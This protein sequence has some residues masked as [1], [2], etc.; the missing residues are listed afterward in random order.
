LAKINSGG[1]GWNR[2][3]YQVVMSRLL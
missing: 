3:N 1:G 2:T